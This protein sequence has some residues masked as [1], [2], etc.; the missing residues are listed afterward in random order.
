MVEAMA[1]GPA[2]AAEQ[3]IAFFARSLRRMFGHFVEHRIHKRHLRRAD[4]PHVWRWLPMPL[5]ERLL[6][7]ILV[8]KAFKP[9]SAAL[10]ALA[11]AA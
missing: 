11:V 9:L 4:V 5:L 8:V 7:R 2:P 6:G 1:A 3:W 10:P